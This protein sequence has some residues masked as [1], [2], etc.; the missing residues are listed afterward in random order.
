[1]KNI[2][3]KQIYV[4]YDNFTDSVFTDDAI[5]FDIETTGFSPNTSAL[6]LIGCL[7]RQGQNVIVEQFFAENK[8]QEQEVLQAFLNR[9]ADFKTIISFNGIGFDIP[10]LKAKCDSFHIPEHFGSY[11]YLD[12]Y[13]LVGNIKFLLKQANYKQKTIEAFLGIHREDKFSGGELINVYDTYIISHC[14][15][16]EELLLL[17]NYEDVLGMQDLLPILTYEQILRGAYAIETV[18][19]CPYTSYE[20]DNGNEVIISLKNDYS[21]PK[22]VSFQQGDFY[23]TINKDTTKVR[24][25]V[26]EGELK[27]FYPN[28]KD[29]FYLPQEDMAIHKSVAEFVDKGYRE[30]AKA[31]NCYNRKEGV[32]LPQNDLIMQPVFLKCHKDKTS[33]FELTEDFLTSDIM[34][35]RYVDHIFSTTIKNHK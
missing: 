5:F 30:R 9:L 17:H 29:Y 6:Y 27:Y 16:D 7:Y 3:N 23:F 35:R 28:Y 15:E 34:L 4:K 19:I 20:G 31:A 11:E 32:F 10:F 14:P 8:S 25:P 26:Y 1:M 13:K 18:D 33:Y 21:V 2:I 12:I 22:R 24:I